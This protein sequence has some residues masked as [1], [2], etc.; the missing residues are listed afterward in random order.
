MGEQQG[1]IHTDRIDEGIEFIRVEAFS[2]SLIERG[3]SVI[4][5]LRR[6]QR[7]VVRPQCRDKLCI[8]QPPVP[9]PALRFLRK[10]LL[11]L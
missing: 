11:P 6:D 8:P 5:N 2:E 1:M 9:R 3:G 10:C 4:D 7:S